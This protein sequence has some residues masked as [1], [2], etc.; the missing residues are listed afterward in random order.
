MLENIAL[1]YISVSFF[2][3]VAFPT[4]SALIE[5][6]CE[7]LY[8]IGEAT[9]TGILLAGGQVASFFVVHVGII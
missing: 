3:F 1:Y 2:G 5:Y 4:I 6:S 9:V 8:P 7:S